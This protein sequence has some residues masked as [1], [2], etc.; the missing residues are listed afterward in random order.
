[1]AVLDDP[2]ERRPDLRVPSACRPVD[3]W[4]VKEVVQEL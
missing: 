3:W 4:N 1:M 2:T